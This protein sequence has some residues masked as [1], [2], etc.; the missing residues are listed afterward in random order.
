M[1]TGLRVL[2]DE[3]INPAV[4][5]GLRKRGWDIRSVAEEQLVG[6]VDADVLGRATA[7]DRVV[8]THDLA[9]GRDS[10]ALAAAFVG[11]VYLRPGHRS[12]DFVLD[13]LAAIESAIRDAQRPFV[14]VAERRQEVVRVRL[15]T[16]PPW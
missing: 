6:A 16:A 14:L 15:R 3:N 7:T 9:F 11:I 12:T 2:A 13:V 1:N 10:L 8:I 4:V 5:A